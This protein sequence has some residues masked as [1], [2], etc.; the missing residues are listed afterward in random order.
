VP[1]ST[2]F[3]CEFDKGDLTRLA[4]APKP[5]LGH[6]TPGVFG[7]RDH[8]YK[9]IV[10]QVITGIDQINTLDFQRTHA[11]GV[12]DPRKA[13]MRWIAEQLNLHLDYKWAKAFWNPDAWNHVFEGS[14]SPTGGN[15]FYFID[16]SNCDPIKLFNGLFTY[17]RQNGLRKPNKLG[18]GMNVYGALQTNEA[19]L[20]R[21]KYMGSEANP[22]TV[23]A[24]VLAQLFGVEEVVVSEAAIN[25]APQGQA[26]DMQFVCDPNAMMLCY[27]TNGPAIDEPTAGYTFAYDMLGN[28]QYLALQSYL[29]EP[30]THSE[31]AE[32]LVA[33]DH[34]IAAQDLCIF[35]KNAV[36]PDWVPSIT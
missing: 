22:A 24:N 33:T 7:K 1:L 31:F 12:I 21:I 5:E 26:D 2:S 15:Q 25:K 17:M 19:V 20:E 10:E 6:V 3:F 30:A 29:G 32:G 9:C 23:T 14:D 35:L 16:N 8:D 11:P 27:T 28:G 18:L 34:R 4:V 36:S 13:K